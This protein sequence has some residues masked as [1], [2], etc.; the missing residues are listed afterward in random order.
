MQ[1]LHCIV[2]TLA[3]KHMTLPPFINNE[4]SHTFD[5]YLSYKETIDFNID[6][7]TN[8]LC[9]LENYKNLLNGDLPS[10]ASEE[11]LDLHDW[12]REE[13]KEKEEEDPFYRKRPDEPSSEELIVENIMRRCMHFV[14][15]Q[16]MQ[17]KYLSLC[18]VEEC[19]FCLSFRKKL[20]LPIT[21]T[22]WK[23]FRFVLREC[24]KSI[25]LKSYDVLL[26]ICN[27]CG[28]FIKRRFEDDVWPTM[29][30]NIQRNWKGIRERLS[31][32][33]LE[34]TIEVKILHQIIKCLLSLLNVS[35]GNDETEIDRK[36]RVRDKE[37]VK[38]IFANL[39]DE[40]VSELIPLLSDIATPKCLIQ[41][42]TKVL[43]L[44][45]QIID[46]EMVSSVCVESSF[47]GKI[48]S[49]TIHKTAEM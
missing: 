49:K 46:R 34:Q 45:A 43:V 11:K 2:Q 28:G 13:K 48:L 35:D 47:Y 9:E 19:I 15:S 10:S 25:V 30:A 16:V 42:V 41:G 12:E 38:V 3:Q 39:A 20:L 27:H 21:A 37:T 1:T 18:I 5:G 7:G 31:T 23:S 26:V 8:I 24:D 29:K 33:D 4:E 36:L 14:S 22:F 32:T 17:T 6:D 44:F 40:I